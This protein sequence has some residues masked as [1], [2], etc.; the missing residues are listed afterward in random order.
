MVT[1][2]ARDDRDMETAK[3]ERAII[4]VARANIYNLLASAYAEPPSVRVVRAITDGTML[5]AFCDAGLDHIA[6]E[7]GAFVLARDAS[8]LLEEMEVE[9]TRLFV[10]P[11]PDYVAPYQSMYSEGL[12]DGGTMLA[13]DGKRLDKRQLWGD[14]AVAAERMY[15]EAGLAVTGE[16]REV[17]DHIALELQFMQH[18]CG[19]EAQALNVGRIQVAEESVR[20]QLAFLE[21]QLAPWIERFCQAVVSTA[22]HP[23]YRGI[24]NL[25][26]GFVL[27]DVE[28]LRHHARSIGD[29]ARA[30]R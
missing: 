15:R 17:P 22:R 21:T 26:L 3:G 28:E 14:S 23:F 18:L 2:L 12:G 27:S 1:S 19:R 4:A 5:R 24:A 10:A 11:G 20:L 9:Y 6:A 13:N 25:T 30:R 7:L 8:D 29:G 16:L